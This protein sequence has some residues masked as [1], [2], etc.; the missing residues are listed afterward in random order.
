MVAFARTRE[1]PEWAKTGGLLTEGGAFDFG[2]NFKPGLF[3]G[4]PAGAAAIVSDIWSSV[5][6]GTGTVVV[7]PAPPPP[8]APATPTPTEDPEMA[9]DWGA[10]LG[11]VAQTAAA[12]YFAPDPVFSSFG[13]PVAAS[14]PFI[15]MSTSTTMPATVA[16]APPMI[17]NACGLDGQVWAG[18][19]P[20]KGYKVVNYCGQATL[21]KIRRRRRRRILS[22]SDAADIA[23]IVGLVGKGQMASALI[24]RRP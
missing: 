15:D 22:A 8:P 16:A 13:M 9:V 5:K 12:G 18:Q 2:W 23:T 1:T 3:G 19:A 20:P 4:L 6:G 14:A 21:R 24:N 17:T 7:A 10:I 11:G